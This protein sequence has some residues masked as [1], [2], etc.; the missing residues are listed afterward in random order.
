MPD[1]RQSSR[2]MAL[3]KNKEEEQLERLKGLDAQISAAINKVKALKEEKLVLEQ[4]V[5]DLET[6][7]NEKDQEVARLS[8]DKAVIK[9]QIEEL[10]EEIE[11]LEVG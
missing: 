6:L 1:M 5:Q 7:L 8:T 10:L 2:G 3:M 9:S 4:R 11:P